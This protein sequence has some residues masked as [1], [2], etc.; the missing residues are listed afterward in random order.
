MCVLGLQRAGVSPLTFALLREEDL[1]ALGCS[2]FKPI[3]T[4]VDPDM[5]SLCPTAFLP[6]F[7]VVWFN[8]LILVE[9]EGC[10]SE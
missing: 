1:E 10:V 3:C 5:K 7:L 6:D 8:L 4:F 9:L 2:A